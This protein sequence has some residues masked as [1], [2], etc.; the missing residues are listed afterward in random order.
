[1]DVAT[2]QQKTIRNVLYYG[3]PILAVLFIAV[4]WVVFSAGHP[5]LMPEPATV[6]ERFI[7]TFTKPIAK[8]TLIGHAW[9]SLRR[10]LMALVVAWAFGISFGILIGWNKIARHS[11]E[12]SSK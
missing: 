6:W 8:T 5:E 12:V 9:A 2:K 3:L 11:L 7:K 1:M 10:V 4:G